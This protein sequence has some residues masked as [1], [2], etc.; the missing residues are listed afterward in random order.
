MGADEEGT[1]EA[2]KSRTAVDRQQDKKVAFDT[3]CLI[4]PILGG[5][6]GDLGTAARLRLF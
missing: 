4:A 3:W 5:D 2:L 1:L 6:L